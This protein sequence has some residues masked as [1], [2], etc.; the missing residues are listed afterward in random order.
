MRI[1]VIGGVGSTEVLVQALVRHGFKQIKLWGYEPAETTPV[2]GWRNLRMLAA[3]LGLTFEKFRMVIECEDS[4]R[5]FAPDVLFVVGLSQIIPPRMLRIAALA[6]VGFHPTALPWGRGR[7]ALAWLILQGKSGAASFFELCDGVDDGPIFVQEP[8]AVTDSDDTA[9]VEASLLA[10]ERLALDRWLPRMLQ[11]NF[12]ATE[13]DNKQASW[14]GR[15]APED[16]W[17]NW[18]LPR[19]V[20][21]RLI[22]A[23]APP[24]PGA[25][26]FCQSHKISVLRAMPVDRQE[27]GVLGRILA[28]H[29]DN[30]FEVQAGDGIIRI[31]Q[32]ENNSGWAPRVGVLLGYY[33]EAE[34]FELRDKVKQLENAVKELKA[35]LE[36]SSI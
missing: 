22:R 2:S 28:V 35:I 10:A 1:A 32:W 7:A 20:L 15:R 23:S 25:Y 27:T 4:L 13:Q 31:A 11:G 36:R 18:H 24:H 34:I 29:T 6:N 14:L 26:S 8:Y 9:D 30:S 21:L 33:A 17:L 5:M 12:S 3:D 16:G 19:E